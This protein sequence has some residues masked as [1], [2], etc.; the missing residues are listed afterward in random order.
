[1][2]FSPGQQETSI[3]NTSSTPVLAAPN[4]TTQR[5]VRNIRISN[6]HASIS[7]SFIVSHEKG[8]T[9]TIIESVFSLAAGSSID[10][11]GPFVLDATD[12]TLEV[13]QSSA[14]TIDV[15][16]PYADRS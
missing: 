1:M 7:A 8:A 2:S 12:E 13:I 3:S 11:P 16:A 10:I 15:L 14:G 5:L 6:T 9:T 4:T